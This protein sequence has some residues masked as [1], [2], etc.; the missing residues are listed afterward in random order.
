MY[1]C[2]GRVCLRS[3]APNNVTSSMRSCSYCCEGS[4][5]TRIKEKNIYVRD[6]RRGNRCMIWET[7]D[8][9]GRVEEDR[10]QSEIWEPWALRASVSLKQIREE[11]FGA[12]RGRQKRKKDTKNKFPL[13]FNFLYRPII[14]NTNV[15][16]H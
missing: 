3:I 16:Q 2:V 4:L 12:R 11:D 14:R 6:K 9:F 13:L 10:R 1:A 7:L 8:T 15:F 5:G